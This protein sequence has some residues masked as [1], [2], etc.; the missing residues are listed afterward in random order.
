M[1]S[2]GFDA[3]VTD[4]NGAT[5]GS[6]ADFPKGTLLILPRSGIMHITN[7]SAQRERFPGVFDGPASWPFTWT[8]PDEDAG[9]ITFLIE[10]IAG[11]NDGSQR[12]DYR[13]FPDAVVVLPSKDSR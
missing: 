2:W 3:W 6:F 10:G 9:P 1:S 8:A 11:N 5:A 7:E 12:G 13:Y 4:E